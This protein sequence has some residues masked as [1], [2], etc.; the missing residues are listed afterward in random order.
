M[1]EE[2][3]NLLTSFKDLFKR[4][5][6]K[7]LTIAA[8]FRSI[9]CFICDYFFPL[10]F[11]TRFPTYKL[12]FSLIFGLNNMLIG[13]PSVML[14]GLVGDKLGEKAYLRICQASS[15]LPIP[16]TI[17]SFYTGNFWVAML[18]NTLKYCV[19]N[20]W[21]SPSMSLMQK[22]IPSKEFGGAMSAY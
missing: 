13:V 10:Y 18:A 9:I 17:L 4:P 19:C 2:K 12:E 6:S 3:T 7:Y 21:F 16:L 5:V 22:T 11:L 1:I 20:M 8:S 15:I 14:G